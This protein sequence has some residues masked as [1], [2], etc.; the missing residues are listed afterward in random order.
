MQKA[1]TIWRGLADWGISTMASSPYGEIPVES[2]PAV[3]LCCCWYR[4]IGRYAI[5]FQTEMNQDQVRRV[6][7]RLQALQG[8]REEIT[9]VG[10]IPMAMSRR[11]ERP[12]GGAECE[13]R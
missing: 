3:T 1:T 13:V 2:A 5:W 6:P 8:L 7:A 9:V 12:W 11:C 10:D 4:A